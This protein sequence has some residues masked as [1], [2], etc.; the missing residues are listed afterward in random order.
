MAKRKSDPV[1]SEVLKAVTAVRDASVEFN[2]AFENFRRAKA[3]LKIASRERD[4]AEDRLVSARD[5]AADLVLQYG[6]VA[7]D[8]TRFYCMDDGTLGTDLIKII[9]ETA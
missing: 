3:A 9:E 8:G 4:E 6:D 5:E 1:L 2:A 7:F